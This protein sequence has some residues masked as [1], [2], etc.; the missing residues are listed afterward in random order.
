M[1]ALDL[2]PVGNCA[3]ASLI[4]RQGRHVWSCFPR[5]DG[6]PAFHALLGWD[7]PDAGFMDVVLRGQTEA[8]QSY[9]ANTAIVETVL[10]DDQGG[11]GD[12]KRRRNTRQSR[13]PA[14]HV[15]RSLTR[16]RVYQLLRICTLVQTEPR[17]TMSIRILP[18][19]LRT[20]VQTG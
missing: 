5:L 16:S 19:R 6:D 10:S 9:L 18:G 7:A 20:T 2:A 17:L 13:N 11:A 8:R 1:S 3:I 12:R 14:P 4:D 15:S